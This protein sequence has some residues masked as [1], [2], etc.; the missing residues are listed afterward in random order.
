MLSG[1]LHPGD[2]QPIQA[3][4]CAILLKPCPNDRLRAVIQ[5]LADRGPHDHAGSACPVHHPVVV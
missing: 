2:A 3:G 1:H 4:V 5:D